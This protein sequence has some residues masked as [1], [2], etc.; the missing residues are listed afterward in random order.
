MKH[1][2]ERYFHFQQPT[3]SH[4]N[5]TTKNTQFLARTVLYKKPKCEREVYFLGQSQSLDRNTVFDD[6]LYCTRRMM[7]YYSTV[8]SRELFA[9]VVDTTL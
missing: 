8:H 9:S 1:Q 5:T 7:I 4:K 6:V 2:S 3:K